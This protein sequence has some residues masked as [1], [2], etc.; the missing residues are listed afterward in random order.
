MSTLNL[1]AIKD[2]IRDQ[3]LDAVRSKDAWNYVRAWPN[4]T[5]SRGAEPS[6]TVPESEYYRKG[7]PHP[8]TIWSI[9]GISAG[10]AESVFEWEECAEDQA[11]FWSDE[12]G[13]PGADRDERHTRPMRLTDSMQEDL[14]WDTI[15]P[16]VVSRLEEA[17]YTVEE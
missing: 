17:G 11:E 7:M 10:P 9:Q 13:Q 3:Y 1:D 2:A 12:H 8:V 15:L 16:P 5:I 14:D 6:E 4:G